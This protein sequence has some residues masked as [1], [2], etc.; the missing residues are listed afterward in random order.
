MYSSGILVIS[1]LMISDMCKILLNTG[2]TNSIWV[3]AMY[4]S[5]YFGTC[6]KKEWSMHFQV[7]DR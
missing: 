3:C 5:T 4:F 6:Y 1:D 7:S 2:D